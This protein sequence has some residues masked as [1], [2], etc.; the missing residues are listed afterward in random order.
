M[1]S[2]KRLIIEGRYESIVTTL[3]REMLN[4]IKSSYAATKSASGVFAGT[5]IY[6]KKGQKIPV[7]DGD[8]FKH[9]YFH[10]VEN[11][12]IPLEFKIALRVQWIEGLN[13]YKRGGDAYNEQSDDPSL[14]TTDPYIEIRFELDP[15]D[16]PNIYSKIA[17]DLRDTIRHE[18]EHITQTGWNLLPGK[19][20][21]SDQKRR[22]QIESGELPAREYF[23]LP[24]EI[25]AMIQGMYLQAKKSRQ[26]FSKIVNNYLDS[27]IAMKDENGESYITSSDKE[28]ILTTW[29]KHIP[30]LGLKVTL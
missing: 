26:P 13:A 8:N 17:M 15:A 12:Q 16:V 1:I 24:M 25:P 3:S 27:F 6:F 5:K 2:L 28:Q 23:L 22:K 10:E 29:R 19:Y 18:I 14:A 21:P 9:I 4:V 30:K 20:L 11:E 7:I